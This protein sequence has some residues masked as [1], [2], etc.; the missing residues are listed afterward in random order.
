MCDRSAALSSKTLASLSGAPCESN[1]A[2]RIRNSMARILLWK[3]R[4]GVAETAPF[5]NALTVNNWPLITDHWP[6]LLILRHLRI[7]AV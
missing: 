5:Q 3:G 2:D 7:Y 4:S 6:L 1:V